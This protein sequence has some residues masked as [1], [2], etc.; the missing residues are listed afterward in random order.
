MNKE[1]IINV[2]LKRVLDDP[3]VEK[4]MISNSEEFKSQ[5]KDDLQR[6][7]RFDYEDLIVD[8]V[9]YI[10]TGDKDNNAMILDL[11]GVFCD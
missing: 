3:L 10:I 5:M 2:R 11:D 4:Y 9:D 6:T 7:L 8:S 1:V